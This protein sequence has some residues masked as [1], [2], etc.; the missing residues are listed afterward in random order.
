MDEL[1]L[2][3]AKQVPA[4][5]VI[6]YLVIHFIRSDK[7]QRDAFL[8]AMD[9]RDEAFGRIIQS[10]GDECHLV[11]QKCVDS[12]DRNT[13]VLGR[14]EAVIDHAVTVISRHEPPGKNNIQGQRDTW[15]AED[16]KKI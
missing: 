2:E 15:D 9:K 12:L 8:A 7:E 1:F 5:V 6:A 13:R 16:G 4:I 14:M 3:I 11:Q 10:M